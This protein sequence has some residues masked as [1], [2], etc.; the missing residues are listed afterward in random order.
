MAGYLIAIANMKGGVGK[1][2]TT[3]SM[4]ETFAA[5]GKSVLIVDLV[6]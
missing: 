6:S 1:T 4:A 3:V 2:T 5:Q